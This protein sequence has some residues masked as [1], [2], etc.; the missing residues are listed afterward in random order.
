MLLMG[1][2][3][4]LLL[5]GMAAGQAVTGVISGTITDAQGRVIP[6]ATISITNEATRDAR[7]GV[8]DDRGDFQITNLQPATYTVRVELA[9]FRSYERKAVVLSAA[10]VMDIDTDLRLEGA[11]MVLAQAEIRIPSDSQLE[12]L[13]RRGIATPPLDVSGSPVPK[14]SEESQIDQMDRQDKAIDEKLMR[15]ICRD[16]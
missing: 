5:P 15:G 1:L 6:G 12:R 8:T 2:A 3:T 13:E 10:L 11:G 7:A 4:M 16:C 9:S 14:G